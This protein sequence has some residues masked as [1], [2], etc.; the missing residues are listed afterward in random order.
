MEEEFWE[1]EDKQHGWYYLFQVN[2]LHCMNYDSDI[3]DWCVVIAAIGP[4]IARQC[5]NSIISERTDECHP[6]SLQRR[7]AK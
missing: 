7:S 1:I 6:K 4:S 5:R 3:M 2:K